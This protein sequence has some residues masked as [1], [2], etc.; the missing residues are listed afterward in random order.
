MESWCGG[1]AEP[2][3]G[4]ERFTIGLV[5]CLVVRLGVVQFIQPRLFKNVHALRNTD[6]L[7]L[8]LFQNC[9]DSI[10]LNH[11]VENAFEKD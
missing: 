2:N 5:R 7:V 6:S 3:F 8:Q 4:F 1:T 10:G 9:F 11:I